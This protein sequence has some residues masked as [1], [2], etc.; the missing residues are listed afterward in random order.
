MGLTPWQKNS[1]YISEEAYGT[2]LLRCPFMSKLMHVSSTNTSG[3]SY[4]MQVR[5][6]SFVHIT[7][8]NLT[9]QPYVHHKKKLSARSKRY[10]EIS[11]YRNT[12]IL[13]KGE[14]PFSFIMNQFI[15]ILPTNKLFLYT[16][17]FSC[18]M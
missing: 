4:D 7:I 11:A 12:N 10:H 13:I 3:K 18:D 9:L 17:Y 15:P 14:I 2:F 16:I 5:R 8:D 1:D 6:K